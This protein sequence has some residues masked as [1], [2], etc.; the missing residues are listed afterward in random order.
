MQNVNY[1][2]LFTFVHSNTGNGT[3]LIKQLL[4]FI[5]SLYFTCWEVKEQIMSISC[6][7]CLFHAHFMFSSLEGD[8]RTVSNILTSGNWFEQVFILYQPLGQSE[9]VF[10]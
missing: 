5:K 2:T 4:K 1:E 6:S 8:I 3:K 10:R 7:P 9:P